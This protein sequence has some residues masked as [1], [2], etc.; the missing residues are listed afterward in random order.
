MKLLIAFLILALPFST[1]AYDKECRN[2]D[3]KTM[4]GSI[5]QLKSVM[6]SPWNRPQVLVVGV[7]TKILN[8]DHSGSPHQKFSIKV[9][10]DIELLIVT[11]LAF[12]RIPVELGKKI[13]ICGEFK[14]VGQGMVHW[15]HFDPHGGHAD[16]FSI[17]DEKLYGDVEIAVK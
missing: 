7:I 12:G 5:E 4:N 16:G 6:S 11:N 3:G 8:E 15:N 9:A 10:N 13:S 1:Q 17:L 2:V 14:K